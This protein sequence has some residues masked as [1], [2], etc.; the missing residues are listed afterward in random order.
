MAG[1]VEELQKNETYAPLVKNLLDAGQNEIF[2]KFNLNDTEQI[3]SFF[4]QIIFAPV[5]NHACLH[6]FTPGSLYDGSF[7]FCQCYLSHIIIFAAIPSISPRYISIC[8]VI[9][10]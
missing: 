7:Y 2:D 6:V 9:C 8:P 4:N 1:I 5:G 3:A 10:P